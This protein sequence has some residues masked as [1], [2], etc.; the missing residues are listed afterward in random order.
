MKTDSHRRAR[1][2]AFGIG[3]LCVVFELLML[4]AFSHANAPEGRLLAGHARCNT[5]VSSPVSP[6]ILLRRLELSL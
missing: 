5:V 3:A 4:I 6:V 2:L 1:S